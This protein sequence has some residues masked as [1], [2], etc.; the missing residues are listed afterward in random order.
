[1][2][3]SNAGRRRKTAGEWRRHIDSAIP[4]RSR[5][6]ELAGRYRGETCVAVLGKPCTADELQQTLRA[7]RVRCGGGA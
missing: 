3:P 1:M 6:A 2:P 5:A 4:S 7:L